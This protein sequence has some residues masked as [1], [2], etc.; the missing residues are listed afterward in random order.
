MADNEFLEI[1]GTKVYKSLFKNEADWNK[2]VE[3]QSSGSQQIKEE[4]QNKK[5]A[6]EE[7][8]FQADKER[9]AKVGVTLSPK[10]AETAKP[11]APV[12]SP[13][14]QAA[15]KAE[16]ELTA[17]TSQPTGPAAQPPQAPVVQTITPAMV[18]ETAITT[19]SQSP[20]AKKAVKM[21]E[22][23]TK[24]SI[25]ANEQ[26]AGFDIQRANTLAAAKER[27]AQQM[28]LD[29]AET[30][31]VRDEQTAQL[32]LQ[33]DKMNATAQEL[34]NYQFKNFFE[35]REGARAMAGLSIALGSVGAAF[36]GGPNYA[37]EIIQNS[38]QNDLAVQKAN[39]DKLKGT[40]E[41]QRSLYGQLVDRFK[42]EN[43]ASQTM[44]RIRYDQ[45]AKQ[46]EAAASKISDPEAKARIATLT[47]QM[48]QEGA[49][50]MMAATE[51]LKTSVQTQIRQGQKQAPIDIIKARSEFE[52]RVKKS[53]VGEA[54]VANNAAEKF[55][56]IIKTG[57]GEAAI[58]DFVAGKAGLG[59]GSVS[60]AFL[61]L[62]NKQGIT[63]LTAENVR[64]FFKGGANPDTLK[65]IQN[66]LDAA[67]VQTAQDSARH[68]PYIA[69]E[70]QLV[71]VD[72]QVYLSQIN[73]RG[74][75]LLETQ[76]AGARRI[77][78]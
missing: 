43:I 74:L 8:Q 18:Q 69:Q 54:I 17:Q 37:M 72:P 1:G 60:G 51:G 36:G 29:L 59:Q 31:K 6:E 76:K 63:D 57:A 16:E 19:V 65:K 20:E 28:E 11:Q 68:M 22:E 3:S 61:D 26:K 44:M 62:M 73:Q 58:V 2:L 13:E 38:I 24:A 42:D 53:P 25:V 27:E 67:A 70:A 35:G 4:F 33:Q 5:Q 9:L 47:A 46:A 71:G 12:V 34:Q 50:A 56:Q 55:R 45:M 77:S 49:K 41:G 40:F 10:P 52:E 7:A 30:K 21:Y 23:A 32:K 39:Y 75:K 64:K 48:K 15:I 14:E 78:P 66:F